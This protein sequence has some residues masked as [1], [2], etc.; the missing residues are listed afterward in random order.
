MAVIANPL[1]KFR[2]RDTASCRL[3]F[4]NDIHLSANG[5]SE[6]AKYIVPWLK[7]RLN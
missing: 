4:D 6:L 1:E 3:Y 2:T 5:Q 7:E